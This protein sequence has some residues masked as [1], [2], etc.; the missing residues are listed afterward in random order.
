MDWWRLGLWL[1]KNVGWFREERFLGATLIRL[2]AWLQISTQI[3]RAPGARS[4]RIA[5]LCL[6]LTPRHTMIAPSLLFKLYD[7][8]EQIL[9][10]GVA[11][12]I[13]ECGVWNGGSAALMGSAA[14]D[15]G[16]LPD[17]WLFDSFQGLPEPTERDP[18][19]VRSGYYRGWNLGDPERVHEAWRRLGLPTQRL[20]VVPGWFE[21]TFPR[22]PVARIAI[23][24]LD[25]DWYQSILSCLEHWWNRMEPG[26]VVIVNDYN[27]YA[28]AN[29]A[30]HEFL[31]ARGLRA[32][33]REL[34]PVGAWFA[35]PADPAPSG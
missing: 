32:E 10:G 9:R 33:I 14:R 21:E 26:G 27:L 12:D 3:A 25:C 28:G 7:L 31:D 11:G 24:H 2:R 8:S 1:R 13:V 34:G 15:A 6:R 20:H 35:R 22:S 30:V 16:R 29:Q 17:F 5:R 19:P 23:L 4:W 18:E